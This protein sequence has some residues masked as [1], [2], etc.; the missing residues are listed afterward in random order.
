M[1]VFA[2]DICPKKAAYYQ[3]LKHRVKMPTETAQMLAFLFDEGKCPVSNSRKSR[4]YSHPAS[5]WARQSKSNALWLLEHGFYLCDAYTDSYIRE[6]ESR[7]HL[8][9]IKENFNKLNIEDKGL[10]DF[11]RCFSKWKDE[12][13]KDK[14]PD[15]IEAHRQFYFHDKIF[16]AKWPSIEE[17][18][19]FWPEK[20][21]IY[22]SKQFKQG[23]YTKRKKILDGVKK[24]E[25][26]PPT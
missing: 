15:T 23:I 25:I 18:P 12:F 24:S 16:I 13:S 3:C 20:L 1:N 8:N 17:I 26:M 19:P 5:V 22:V 10:T 4:H 14:I 2:L 21:A 11:A 9:W 6:H 7:N